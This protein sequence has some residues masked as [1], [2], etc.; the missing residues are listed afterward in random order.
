MDQKSNLFYIMINKH[1]FYLIY[2]LLSW[3]KISN[4]LPPTKV[5]K[6]N[7]VLLSILN[8]FYKEML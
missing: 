8:L 5:N 3:Y 2:L 4:G 7:F 1:A 6:N